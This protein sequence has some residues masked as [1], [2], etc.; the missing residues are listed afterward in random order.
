MTNHWQ[1]LELPP[2][3]D[4][5]SIKRAYA[6]LLKT[7]R[8]DENADNFQRLRQAYEASLAEARWRAEGEA[9]EP[10][11]KITCDRSPVQAPAAEWSHVQPAA[12]QANTSVA[13]PPT[14]SLDQMQQWL[15]DGQDRRVLEGL[16]HWLASDWL[17]PLERRQQFDRSVFDW[18]EAAEGWSP[19]FFDAVCQMMQWD[20]THGDLP[21]E[22]WRWR[23]MIRRCEVQAMADGFNA[24]LE[25]FEGNN[26]RGRAATLLLKP[27]TDTRRR[28][29]ADRCEGHDWHR[30]T[31]LAHTFE[32]YSPEL[33]ERLGLQPLN[34]WRNW[35]PVSSHGEVQFFLWLAMSWVM[36]MA[37]LTRPGILIDPVATLIFPFLVPVLIAIGRKAYSL[38][39][40]VAVFVG[41]VDVVIS[42]HLVPAR[43]YRG[44][45][46]LLVLRHVLPMAIP[47]GLAYMWSGPLLWLKV[48]NPGVV[49]LGTLYFT[50]M[51]LGGK[52]S[53]LGRGS[54]SAMQQLQ[55]LPWHWLRREAM[56]AVVA[57]IGAAV[58]MYLS[59]QP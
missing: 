45:A 40:Q 57:V 58:A 47:A 31:E 21:V 56:L 54:Q 32:Y 11:H 37:E 25:T 55:R 30:F 46:G 9:E 2:D 38:W 28:Q 17:L 42:K 1:L 36:I 3:A 10:V 15:A 43:W 22:P 5:R 16:R 29:L 14:P 41:A 49:C 26:A 34:N 19:A 20:D 48:A 33:P 12:V 27:L 53:A 4:E 18:L 13:S 50:N 39:T 35:L 24:E 52:A 51:A 44:G 23:G 7:H 8:P 6:R 59:V